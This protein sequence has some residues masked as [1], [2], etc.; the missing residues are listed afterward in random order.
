MQDD[1]LKRRK[2]SARPDHVDP[3]ETH[4]EYPRGVEVPL[5]IIPRKKERK[6]SRPLE[7]VLVLVVTPQKEGGKYGRC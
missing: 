1:T 4:K 3:R 5:P 7:L 2:T 6:L